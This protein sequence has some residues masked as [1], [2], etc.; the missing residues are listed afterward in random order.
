MQA[1]Q[2]VWRCRRCGI[3]GVAGGAALQAVSK[4]PLHCSHCRFLYLQDPVKII[5]MPC[6]KGVVSDFKVESKWPEGLWGVFK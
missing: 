6:L 3:T 1:L 4:Y 2:A 5:A